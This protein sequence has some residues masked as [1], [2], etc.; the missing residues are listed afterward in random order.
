MTALVSLAGAGAAGLSAY[1]ASGA[2]AGIVR[3]RERPASR[4]G[5]ESLLVRVRPALASLGFAGGWAIVGGPLGLVIG[6]GVAGV[7]WVV[8]GRAEGPD[9]R[10]RR[11][12]LQR[13]L[14]TGVDL[15]GSCLLAGGAPTQSLL[16]VAD[17]LGG[18][19]AE[20]FL[21]IH[22]RLSLGV[23]PG[24]VWRDVGRH[25]QLGP[26]G[27]S[28]ARAHDS[29]ASVSTAVRRLADEL[30]ALARAEVEMRAK[31]VEVKAAAPLG[32]C[33]MPAFILLGIVPLVAGI[34]TLMN[35][36]S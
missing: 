11:E 28:L 16:V 5:R 9:V 34:F 30:R 26:L 32:A 21:V 6:L 29:G 35:L 18:P 15:L 36:F 3:V 23:D 2:A 13:E 4:R 1:L 19:V 17:A 24:T 33:F 10:R 14:P 7:S 27:R 22:H 31:S 20:E 12:R 8:L 25:P